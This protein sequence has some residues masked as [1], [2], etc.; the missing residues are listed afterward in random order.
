MTA[1]RLGDG[2]RAAASYAFTEQRIPMSGMRFGFRIAADSA[3]AYMCIQSVVFP[4]AAVSIQTSE[5]TA[6]IKPAY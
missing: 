1:E 5:I 2:T 3:C 4:Y 6:F